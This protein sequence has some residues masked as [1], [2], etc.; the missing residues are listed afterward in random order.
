MKLMA[1]LKIANVNLR[2]EKAGD[3]E[4]PI[5]VDLK[6]T[7]TMPPEQLESMFTTKASYKRLLGELWDKDSE[8]VTHDLS[9]LVLAREGVGVT[10]TLQ[11]EFT[12]PIEFDGAELNR[13]R[14][15]PQ[16][17]RQ[18]DFVAR[19]QVHPTNDQVKRL[20]EMLDDHVNVVIHQRQQGLDLDR[21]A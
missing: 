5:A 17:G 18:V 6:L 19:L 13:I 7:G 14:I 3:D 10:A 11:P 1:N 9:H 21:A 2:R 16:G 20:A 4:G 12:D 8:L 15:T